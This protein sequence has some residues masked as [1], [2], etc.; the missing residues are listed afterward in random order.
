MATFRRSRNGLFSLTLQPVEADVLASV[1]RE[2]L[3]LLDV[4]E[5]RVDPLAAELGLGDL[6]AFGPLDEDGSTGST[7]STSPPQ[8]EVLRRLLPDAYPEDPDAAA[9]FRRFTEHGLRERKA[10]AARTVLASLAP[11]EGQ[12]G[13]VQL[14]ADGAR[15]WLA[16]L[17]DVRLA[18]GTRLGVRDDD[19]PELLDEDDPARYAWAVYDFTTHLQET[20]VRSLG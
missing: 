12:G 14:D 3:E 6:P 9:E 13:R 11:V 2:V 17:N 16:A 4:P 19:G 18:L 20:L 15:T 1:T 7:G 5:R 10:A 8:D